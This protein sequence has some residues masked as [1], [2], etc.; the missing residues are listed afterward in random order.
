MTA[1]ITK[2]FSSQ[3][4]STYTTA[5]WISRIGCGA[6]VIACLL[7]CIS[8]TI[9]AQT[10][11][12]G[13]EQV[14]G[15][16]TEIKS[17]SISIKTSSGD[18]TTYLIQDKTEKAISLDAFRLRFG[19]K[20]RVYGNIPLKLIEKGMVVKL[21]CKLNALGK[22]ESDIEAAQLVSNETELGIDSAETPETK[23]AFTEATVVGRV[24]NFNN[25][26][27]QLEVPKSQRSKKGKLSLKTAEDANLVIDDNSLAR[28]VPG[29]EVESATA[30]KF[31]S[32]EQAIK[33]IKIKLVAQRDALTKDFADQLNNKFSHLSDEPKPAR[34]KRSAHFALH[35]DIS[36]R[37]AQ[38][39]LAKLETMYDLVSGY[40]QAR[41]RGTI[42]CYVVRDLAEW[43]GQP[44]PERGRAKILEPA[45]VT[46]SKVSRSKAKAV[47]YSCDNQGVAQHEAVHAFC[48]QTF[49]STGPTWYSEGMAEMG[50]YWKKG[51]LAV[52]IS[53]YVAQYLSTAKPKKLKDIVALGQKTGDSWEAYSWR[54]ALCHLLA[55]NPNYSKRFKTLGINLMKK[56][57]D[58]FD[59]AF[60][61]YAKEISFEYDQFIENFGNGYRADLCAWDWSVKSKKLSGSRKVKTKVDALAGW[62]ATKAI[63]VAGKTYTYQTTGKWQFEPTGEVDADGS[64]N[65]Q[66]RLIG[67]ILKDYKLSKPFELGTQGEFTPQGGGQLYLRCQDDWLSLGDNS[68]TIEM[69]LQQKK[70]K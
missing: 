25:N 23:S 33:G 67:V 4:R 30:Y 62:Q 63:V 27:L 40:Y 50:Q 2:F 18:T 35:T 11:I 29:D 57:N 21:K 64:S 69:V 48:V 56:R 14:S 36:D 41:P 68:G 10:R 59:Q 70:E 46:L 49:G 22:I 12:T 3:N 19:G 52:D 42:E 5:T 55:S 47:V 44:I 28:V 53:P 54:W 20:I 16:V 32:G 7:N 61:L 43:T 65:G 34:V 66:G 24:T 13:T 17:G 60:G 8:Q 38:V 31:G 6:L 15:T 9:F 51:N 26:R 58:S 1:L 45:G 37:Q 39:L